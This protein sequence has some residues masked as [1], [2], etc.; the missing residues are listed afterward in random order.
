MSCGSPP[1]PLLEL[2]SEGAAATG[3]RALFSTP[4]GV[5]E[6]VIAVI[7]PS[8]TERSWGSWRVR[9]GL[10]GECDVD[11]STAEDSEDE[12]DFRAKS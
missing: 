8:D 12:P 9:G 2:D 10:F 7:G 1:P 4:N 11:S 5:E 6:D 3:L